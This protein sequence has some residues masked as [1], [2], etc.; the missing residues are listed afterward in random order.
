MSRWRCA[1]CWA[2][3]ILLGHVGRW[4]CPGEM[5]HGNR[6]RA[7]VNGFHGR[8]DHAGVAGL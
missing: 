7:A 2:L 1:L 6:D 3:R 4:A 8:Q 5:P